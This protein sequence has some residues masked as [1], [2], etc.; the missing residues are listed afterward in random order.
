MKYHWVKVDS[1]WNWKGC[2]NTIA[3]K[4]NQANA[5]LHR[6]RDF[7]NINIFKSIYYALFESHINYAC[8]IWEQNI[9]PFNC[10]YIL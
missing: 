5:I 7:V 6:V 4:L 3:T 10:L 2:V 1:K 8:I 9:S